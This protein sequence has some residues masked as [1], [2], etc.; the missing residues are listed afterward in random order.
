M[1]GCVDPEVEADGVRRGRRREGGGLFKASDW[2]RDVPVGQRG[3]PVV[4][5]SVRHPV[6]TDRRSR[7]AIADWVFDPAGHAIEAADRCW[8]SARDAAYT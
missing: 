7:I 5:P 1:L 4:R 8:V 3:V 6:G 2:M